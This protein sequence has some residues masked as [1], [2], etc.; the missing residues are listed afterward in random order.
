MDDSIKEIRKTAD[1]YVTAK[2]NDYILKDGMEG[3]YTGK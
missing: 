2:G 1:Y 3:K